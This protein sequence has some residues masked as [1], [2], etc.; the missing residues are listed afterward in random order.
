M[1]N[2]WYLNA[3]ERPEQDGT[4]IVRIARRSDLLSV[5]SEVQLIFC[6]GQWNFVVDGIDSIDLYVHSWR[7]M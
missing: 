5:Y 7:E 1:N 6:D 2:K 4:Y 3:L